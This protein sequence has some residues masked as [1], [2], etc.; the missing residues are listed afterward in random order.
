MQK[1]RFY[2]EGIQKSVFSAFT[3]KHV[4]NMEKLAKLA[5]NNENLTPKRSQN[6]W[7]INAKNDVEKQAEKVEKNKAQRRPKGHRVNE[8]VNEP[9]GWGGVGGGVDEVKRSLA[10]RVLTR[11]IPQRGSAD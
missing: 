4:N 2:A 3:K 9:G 11:S 1:Q 10:T 8:R 7:K 5:S 6:R